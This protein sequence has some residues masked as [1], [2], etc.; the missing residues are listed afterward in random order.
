M[1]VLN[2]GSDAFGIPNRLAGCDPINHDFK[3]NKTTFMGYVNVDC[4]DLPRVQLNHV[5]D[6]FDE[7]IEQWSVIAAA[8]SYAS[9]TSTT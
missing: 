6:L 2:A 8:S 5:Q 7:V 4:F 9:A 1:G 3:N